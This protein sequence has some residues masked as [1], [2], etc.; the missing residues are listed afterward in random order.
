MTRIATFVKGLIG[1]VERMKQSRI[2][3]LT[4]WV[5]LIPFAFGLILEGM[6]A[7]DTLT[8][9]MWVGGGL[10]LFGGG[11]ALWNRTMKRIEA[12][13]VKAEK[14][15]KKRESRER[16]GRDSL[17]VVINDLVKEIREDRAN[18]NTTNG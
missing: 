16:K 6:H 4:L 12:E 3:A 2:A 17:I 10:I 14:E 1:R 5:T 7:N 8:R 18:R 15:A 13:E 9:L 11:M